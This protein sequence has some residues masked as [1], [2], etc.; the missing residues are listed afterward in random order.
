[1][2]ESGNCVNWLEYT[3]EMLLHSTDCWVMGDGGKAVGPFQIHKIYLLDANEILKSK[4][5]PP[6]FKSV[7]RLD[8]YMSRSITTTVLSYYR[9]IWAGK[10][11]KMSDADLCAMHRWGPT[12]WKPNRTYAL[13]IDRVRACKLKNYMLE[14]AL[15]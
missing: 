4:G 2:V 12:R 9:D 7:D 11:I 5:C 8:Y 10:G 3:P 14:L 6:I 15:K 13:Q 1:M